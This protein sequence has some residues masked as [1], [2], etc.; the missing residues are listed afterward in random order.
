M[1][2][3]NICLLQLRV[4]CLASTIAQPLEV[5]Y[6]CGAERLAY[7]LVGIPEEFIDAG[8]DHRRD[9]IHEDHHL[10]LV[11]EIEWH[12]CRISGTERHS[13]GFILKGRSA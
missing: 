7:V 8:V 3:V 5:R 2:S 13:F 4:C 11:S 9:S 6:S 1:I 10:I 12:I